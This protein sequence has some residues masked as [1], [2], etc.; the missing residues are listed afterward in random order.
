MKLQDVQEAKKGDAERKSI[1]AIE[2]RGHFAL[3]CL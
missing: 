1:E 3:I 2:A